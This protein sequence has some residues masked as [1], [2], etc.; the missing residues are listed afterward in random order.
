MTGMQEFGVIFGCR[1]STSLQFE[2]PF[3]FIVGENIFLLIPPLIFQRNPGKQTKLKR[4]EHDNSNGSDL[5]CVNKV[6][7]S[8]AIANL[9]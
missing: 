7:I 9:I 2:L 3:R 4:S 6:Q 1:E 8:L 5:S